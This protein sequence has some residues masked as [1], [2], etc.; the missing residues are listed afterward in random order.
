MMGEVYPYNTEMETD[1][2]FTLPLVM[3][4][5]RHMTLSG[6]TVDLWPVLCPE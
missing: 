1:G 2:L 5:L 4:Q 3:V 6:L